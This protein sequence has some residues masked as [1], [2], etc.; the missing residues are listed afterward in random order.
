M[1]IVVD[2]NI[3]FSAIISNK[4]KIGELLL[5]KPGD[6][7]FFSPVFLL[8]ELE[9]HYQRILDITEYNDAEYQ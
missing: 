9:H 2:T 3:I 1:K 7:Y 4:G 8:D 5:N 6:L